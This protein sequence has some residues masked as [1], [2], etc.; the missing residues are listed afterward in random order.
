MIVQLEHLDGAAVVDLRSAAAY[1]K[2][3]FGAGVLMPDC[4]SLRGCRPLRPQQPQT[5]EQE[6]R[7]SQH[8]ESSAPLYPSLL[9]QTLLAS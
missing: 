5:G 4:P 2:A 3:I 8:V 9:F 6:L 7:T 1:L